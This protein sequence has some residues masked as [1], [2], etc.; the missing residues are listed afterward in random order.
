MKF[1]DHSAYRCYQCL[2][3]IIGSFFSAIAGVPAYAADPAVA[4]VRYIALD[5]SYEFGLGFLSDKRTLYVGGCRTLHIEH[6]DFDS[7]CRYPEN[8]KWGHISPDGT[9]LL[10]TTVA[11]G[12]STAVSYQIDTLT[13]RI[14]SSHPGIFFS[15]PI[16]IHT[17]NQFWAATKAGRTA[18]AS[19]TVSIIGTDWRPIKSGIYAGSQRLFSLQFSSDGKQLVAN[20]GDPSDGAVLSAAT[21]KPTTTTEDMT[22]L[23]GLLA[24]SPDHRLGFKISGKSGIVVNLKSHE[25]VAQLDI[26]MTDEEPQAAFSNDGHWLAAK[27]YRLS[28]GERS[29]AVAIIELP[30]S[31]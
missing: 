24:W 2:P 27:G 16:A 20:G 31:E 7:R 8:M 22:E 5:S 15:P 9:L 12:K 23:G 3:S 4:H 19:E 11:P 26:D 30:R 25:T 10:A 18:A 14:Q 29:Y 13:G 17:S 28:N 6:G 21:W 1:S